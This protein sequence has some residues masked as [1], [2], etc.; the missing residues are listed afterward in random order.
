MEG[1]L[2]RLVS[3]RPLGKE[4]KWVEA[5]WE[6]DFPLSIFYFFQLQTIWKNCPFMPLEFWN[7]FMY[8]Q[9]KKLNWKDFSL[10]LKKK[11]NI[12]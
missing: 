2:K 3:L 12:I 10:D 1:Y 9:L 4:A 6:E 5:E 8:Y 7:M 11:T